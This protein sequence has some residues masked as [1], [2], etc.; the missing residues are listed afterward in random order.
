MSAK[1]R[2][3]S[4]KE[5]KRLEQKRA[6][7]EAKARS[8]SEK[9]EA[10]IKELLDL[11]A[12]GELAPK[13]EESEDT[14]E[15]LK[16]EVQEY[17]AEQAPG[18]APG[19]K[20]V[21]PRPV[22]DENYKSR[23]TNK[24]VRSLVELVA[25]Q[26]DHINY[27]RR[28][29]QLCKWAETHAPKELA[30]LQAVWRN[31]VDKLLRSTLR[32]SAKQAYEQRARS[33]GR[34]DEVGLI[35]YEFGGQAEARA[36]FRLSPTCLDDIFRGCCVTMEDLESRFGMERHRF[37]KK[38]RSVRDG[39]K[40]LYSAL[41]VVKIMDTLLKEKLP[42]RK[43]G[44]RGGSVKKLWLSDPNRRKRVLMGIANRA[45]ALSR[46]KKILAAFMAVV[47][48]HLATEF[49][50]EQLPEGFEDWLARLGRRYLD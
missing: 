46:Y 40:I 22:R 4:E 37:P 43:R 36:G 48:R 1:R 21:P 6:E 15:H 42:E 23:F 7:E 5:Y 2:R 26:R 34:G 8:E 50:R 3:L 30:A 29:H 18:V 44:A 12:S 45:L 24:L 28:Y 32:S 27:M 33:R 31:V 9:R 49:P 38:L 11:I 14:A 25:L 16:S 20:A 41:A 17:F 19:E 47:C 39:R 10:R 13:G 35:E